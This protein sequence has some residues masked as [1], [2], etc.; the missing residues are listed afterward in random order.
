MPTISQLIRKPASVVAAIVRE[1]GSR[2]AIP[3]KASRI[4]PSDATSD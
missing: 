3:M 1:T 4:H 2:H